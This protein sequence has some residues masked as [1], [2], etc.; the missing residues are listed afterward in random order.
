MKKLY[1]GNMM[2][3][4]KHFL[5]DLEM[6]EFR[7]GVSHFILEFPSMIFVTYS[8]NY[9]IVIII[10]RLILIFKKTLTFESKETVYYRSF[11]MKFK[12]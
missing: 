4:M 10:F 2:Q 1:K 8:N 6:V 11:S 9:F 5:K 7:H 3:L 12:M